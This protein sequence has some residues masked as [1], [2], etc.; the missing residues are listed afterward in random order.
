MGEKKKKKKKKE[1]TEKEIKDN[2]NAEQDDTTHCRHTKNI[3]RRAAQ[4]RRRM[5]RCTTQN[6]TASTD[7]HSLSDDE[8]QTMRERRRRNSKREQFCDICHR[9]YM[10]ALLDMHGRSLLHRFRLSASALEQNPGSGVAQPTKL[11][12]PRTCV[13]ER[14]GRTRGA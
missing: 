3:T 8:T 2:I 10:H 12:C 5:A 11:L 6:K 7:S 4:S 9:A 14:K 1:K 13:R